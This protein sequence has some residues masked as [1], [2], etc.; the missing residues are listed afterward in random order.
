LGAVELWLV[1]GLI[2]G[3]SA[4]TYAARP[5]VMASNCVI[6]LMMG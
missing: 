5:A 6:D 1:G 3:P 2:E 4:L